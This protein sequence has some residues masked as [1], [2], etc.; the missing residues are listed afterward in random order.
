MPQAASF[1][2][3]RLQSAAAGALGLVYPENCQLCRDGRAGAA[4][5]F[6]CARC[7][8]GVRFVRPPLC[9][10]CGLPF[11]GE[12]TTAFECANCREMTLHFESARAAVVATGVVLEVVHRFK[13]QQAEW[14]EPFLA[15]LLCREAVPVLRAD[16]WDAVV[17]VPL[18]P[19]KERERGFNQAGRLAAALGRAL[20]RPVKRDWVRRVEFTR[21]QTLLTR[22]E[23]AANMRAA[24]AAR[25]GLSLRGERIVLVDDVLTTGATTSACA[26]ALLDAG[27]G[28]VTVWTLARGL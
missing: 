12:I 22:A 5:G 27:A 23:R 3:A 6:V 8:Q 9:D 17:P 16:N 25:P 19:R 2:R 18:H 20:N 21:T 13:Y 26:K 10:R 7:W 24:F 28:R 4:E 15:D 14:F 1:L 11:E